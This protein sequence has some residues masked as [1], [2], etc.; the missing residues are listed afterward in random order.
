[1]ND[2]TLRLLRNVALLAG[3]SLFVLWALSGI[4]RAG[5]PNAELARTT[6]EA[7]RM[8]Q[9]WEHKRRWISGLTSVFRMLALVTGVAAPL[10]AV[11][12][13]FR[14]RS[15]SPITPEEFLEVL[16]QEGL[17]KKKTLPASGSHL[18]DAQNTGD[19]ADTTDGGKDRD[20][21]DGDD[22]DVGDESAR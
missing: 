5:Q 17:I 22:G 14:H 11:Y 3:L 1:M 20:K 13:I 15:R 18:L 10:A 2:K 9:D 12:L 16:R 7:V 6:R 8:V 4:F 21:R 19:D